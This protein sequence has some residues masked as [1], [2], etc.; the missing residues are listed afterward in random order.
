MSPSRDNGSLWIGLLGEA[1]VAFAI[2]FVA[3]I[4]CLFAAIVPAAAEKRVALVVGNDSYAALAPAEQLR[5]AVN[6]ANA[7]GDALEAL[8]FDVLAGRT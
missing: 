5:K 8:G 1:E 6:D 4:V 7:V 2:R 3:L